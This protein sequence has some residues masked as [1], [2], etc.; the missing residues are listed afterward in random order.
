MDVKGHSIVHINFKE[1]Q[2]AQYEHDVRYMWFDLFGAFGGLCGVTFGGS[3]M[4]IIELIYHFS[5]RFGS[6]C[7]KKSQNQQKRQIRK[8]IYFNELPLYKNKTLISHY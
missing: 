1:N 7:T 6:Q 3:I 8:P 2:F 5:G 4:N